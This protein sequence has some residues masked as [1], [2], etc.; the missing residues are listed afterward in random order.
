MTMLARS[1]A[2]LAALALLACA[3]PKT[4][5]PA[6]EPATAPASPAGPSPRATLVPANV[7]VLSAQFGLFGSDPQGRRVLFETDRF[8]AV[9]A[10]PYGWYVV[11]KTDKPT[12]IWREEFELPVAPPTWGPGEAMGVFSVS[13]DRRTAVTERIIPTRVGFVSNEWR[14]AP[15]DPVGAHKMRVYLD[16]QLV[17]EFSFEIQDGP[18]SRRGPRDEGGTGSRV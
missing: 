13:P 9:T 2:P 17:K 12:V 6:L 14:Y 11:F 1:L 5:T 3:A 18:G 15:G 7:D 8:P 10:A 4:P 16:G